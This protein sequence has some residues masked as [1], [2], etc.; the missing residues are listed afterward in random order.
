MLNFDLARGLI[1]L[2]MIFVHVSD[3]YGELA[4][5]DSTLSS[6]FTFLGQARSAPVFMFIMGLFIPFSPTAALQKNLKR[7]AMLFTLGYLR[8]D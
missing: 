6:V 5:Q 7:A 2:Y 1:I 8:A 3:F 4:Y